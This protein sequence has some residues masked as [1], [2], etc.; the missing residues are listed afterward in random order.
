MVA[1]NVGTMLSVDGGGASAIP[2]TEQLTSKRAT[3][4]RIKRWV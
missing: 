1:V 4:K 3:E 2:E